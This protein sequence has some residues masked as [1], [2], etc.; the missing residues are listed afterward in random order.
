MKKIFYEFLFPFYTKKNWINLFASLFYMYIHGHTPHL[1]NA[2]TY[3]M[4]QFL[5]IYLWQIN[6]F[7]IVKQKKYF[8]AASKFHEF[9]R[10][11]K[12]T[13]YL[14]KLECL[15]ISG[16]L[17]ESLIVRQNMFFFSLKKYFKESRS[18]RNMFAQSCHFYSPN[19]SREQ[20]CNI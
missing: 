9:L 6:I 4:M 18:E 13:R 8:C 11:R 5:K 10:A 14:R 1:F 16:F 17:I 15:C 7:F 3:K 2:I 12:K 20:I 19:L